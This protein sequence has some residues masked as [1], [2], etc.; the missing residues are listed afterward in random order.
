MD[1]NEKRII[2]DLFSRL[3]QAEIQSG[4]RDAEAEKAI[5]NAIARQP[6]AP[7]YMAQAIIVQEQ[8]L[9]NLNNRVQELEEEL[10]QRPA[11]GSF[12]AELFGGGTQEKPAVERNRPSASSPI[13]STSRSTPSSLQTRRVGFLGGAL[14]TATAVAGGMLL[15]NAVGSLFADEAE[16][17]TAEDLSTEPSTANEE[18]PFEDDFSDDFSDDFGGD[19]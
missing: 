6:A 18:P 7:Y 16:A 9:Q 11:G 2:G 8:A 13:Q 10:Q 14:Q 4:T 1:Q 17:S 5:H 15:A 3:Q 19:F 12:L